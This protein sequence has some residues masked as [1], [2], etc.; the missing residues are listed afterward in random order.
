MEHS[1]SEGTPATSAS[2]PARMT[3]APAEDRIEPN[4]GQ[5]EVST[6][7]KNKTKKQESR[8]EALQNKT[9]RSVLVYT[10]AIQRGRNGTGFFNSTLL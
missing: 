9:T 7:K 10:A 3:L 5:H 8:K 1:L 4:R 2:F 6:K